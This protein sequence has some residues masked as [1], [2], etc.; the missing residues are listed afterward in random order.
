MIPLRRSPLRSPGA[1]MASPVSS[2]H[3]SPLSPTLHSPIP[4]YAY[5]PF[6]RPTLS[7]SQPAKSVPNSPAHLTGSPR[8]SPSS[9]KVSRKSYEK[10]R[11]PD[12]L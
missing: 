7:A 5:S 4:P 3:Q 8:Y 12:G 9:N 1:G 2:Y 10:M 11:R 6:I